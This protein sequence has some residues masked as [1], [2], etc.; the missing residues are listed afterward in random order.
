MKNLFF[1]KITNFSYSTIVRDHSY[2]KLSYSWKFTFTNAYIQNTYLSMHIL[3][4]APSRSSTPLKHT[5]KASRALLSLSCMILKNSQA[6]FK[7]LR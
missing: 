3:I 5:F 6:Y 1:L 2:L 4:F 7:V